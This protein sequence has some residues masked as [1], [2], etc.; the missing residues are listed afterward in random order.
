[1]T[2][3]SEHQLFTVIT[4]ASS[5]LGKALAY[6]CGEKG[7]NLVL[8]ALPHD[9]L[10]R[11]A[12]ELQKQFDIRVYAFELDLTIQ[13]DFD[14]L[15]QS[16]DDI[17]VNWLINN[18]GKGGTISFTDVSE[19]YLT[20]IINLNVRTTCL[21]TYQL[22]PK[23]LRH[24]NA[25]ILNISSLLSQYPTAFKTI[26]PASKSFIHSF[27]LGLR[28]E[29]RNS[30]VSV[31]VAELGPMLT[32][33]DV[34]RRLREKQ[35]RAARMAILQTEI[36]AKIVIDQTRRKRGLIIP[37]AVNKLYWL[38]MKLIPYRI[39]IPYL[40]NIYYREKNIKEMPVPKYHV[41]ATEMIV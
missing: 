4:G 12:G 8:I 23:L 32:N 11:V 17:E 20:E 1:M 9:N 25:F 14:Y 33:S 31:S 22:L 28:H 27:S 3:Q 30:G 41:E 15:I 34:C 10:L 38:C 2:S 5:G 18:V 19:N 39:G 7:M 13:N 16:L 24:K 6:E 21:L 35:K 26:Y 29:L 36:V 40:S 37:G